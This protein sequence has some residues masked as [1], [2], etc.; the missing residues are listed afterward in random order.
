MSWFKSEP[1][2]E[3]ELQAELKALCDRVIVQNFA[4]SSDMA[5]YEDLLYEMYLRN[6]E[7]AVKLEPTRWRR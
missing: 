4:Y 1:K 5:R 3:R 6:I 2:S 7:P